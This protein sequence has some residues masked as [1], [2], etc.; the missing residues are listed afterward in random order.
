MNNILIECENCKAKISKDTTLQVFYGYVNRDIDVCT[1]CY[2]VFLY[3]KTKTPRPL[4]LGSV[5]TAYLEQLERLGQSGVDELLKDG[6]E[7]AIM[8]R[9]TKLAPPVP[10]ALLCSIVPETFPTKE[11]KDDAGD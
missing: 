4:R 3:S 1:D 10:W 8:A 7:V 9:R 11:A 6:A 5:L 2:E